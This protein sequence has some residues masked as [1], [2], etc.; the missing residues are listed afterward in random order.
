MPRYVVTATKDV[1]YQTII[2]APN[3]E[4]AWMIADNPTEEQREKFNWVQTDDGHD[5]TL[6]NVWEFEDDDLQEIPPHEE[7]EVSQAANNDV[8]TD[9]DGLTKEEVEAID[10]KIRRWEL[11]FHPLDETQRIFFRMHE[12]HHLKVEKFNA[13][14]AKRMHEIRDELN[15]VMKTAFVECEQ[16]Q[17]GAGK[18][19]LEFPEPVQLQKHKANPPRNPF[20]SET[21]SIKGH[22]SR[23]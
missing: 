12:A 1:G 14:H 11:E 22:K 15:S 8:S 4:T 5:W 18:D 10:E 13:S 17:M 7:F 21:Q 20:A 16:G 9:I 19:K 6:E 3:E 2:E 23:K